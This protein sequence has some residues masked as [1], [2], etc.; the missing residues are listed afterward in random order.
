MQHW[1][2]LQHEANELDLRLIPHYHRHR[3][4]QRLHPLR[5]FF[6]A[7]S[8]GGGGGTVP[9]NDDDDDIVNVLV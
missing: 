5:F 1:H 3:P 9:D 6:L 4:R 7:G 2:R 8:A